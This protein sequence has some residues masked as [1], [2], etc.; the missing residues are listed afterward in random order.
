MA[1]ITVNDTTYTQV[2]D[3]I[4]FCI[5]EAEV[6]YAFGATTPTDADCFTL[7]PRAQINGIDGMILWAKAIAYSEVTVTSI[8]EA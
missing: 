4:G 6:R 5:S 3:G 1:R 7:D 8:T 2:L